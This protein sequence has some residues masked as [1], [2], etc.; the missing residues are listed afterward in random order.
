MKTIYPRGNGV[1]YAYDSR[2]N[3]ISKREKTDISAAD[4]TDD[5]ITTYTYDGTYDVRT[6][7]SFPSGLAKTYT[8]DNKGNV[9]SES[10]SGIANPDGTTYSVTSAFE[11]DSL[12]QRVRA[13]NPEGWETVFA[14]GS[15]QLIQ[16]TE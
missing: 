12:G 9:I 16:T 3:I 10:I 8:L 11:H 2:G 4:S 6:S 13:I 14:Y 15:G 5:L 7:E 1:K